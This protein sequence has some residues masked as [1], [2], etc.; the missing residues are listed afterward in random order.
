MAYQQ[1]RAF[2]PAQMGTKKGYCLMNARLGFGITKGTYPSA[3]ADM[4]AQ[5]REGTFHVELPP[6]N[7]AVPV[8]FNTSSPYEHVMVCDHGVY[9]S[10]GKIINPIDFNV[11]KP[12]GWGEK[13]DGE[14]VVNVVPDPEPTP[15]PEPTPT[16]EPTPEPKVKKIK[17]SIPATEIELELEEE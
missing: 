16:P 17:L 8:Y 15:E 9:Y 2:D 14:R 3:K 11:W 7:I 1:Y 12:F 4:D 6:A 5:I 10:D 13:C